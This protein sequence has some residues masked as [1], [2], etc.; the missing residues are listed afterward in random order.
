[1]GLYLFVVLIFAFLQ[2]AIIALVIY[3]LIKFIDYVTE[4]K[5]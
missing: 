2:G 5:N 3:A 1:M 4:Q